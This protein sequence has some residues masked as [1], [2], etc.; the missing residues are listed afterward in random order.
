MPSSKS[1]CHI[2]FL[3]AVIDVCHSKIVNVLNVVYGLKHSGCT[4]YGFSASGTL[5]H[6]V[7]THVL[8]THA[9]TGHLAHT[10]DAHPRQRAPDAHVHVG[11]LAH[12]RC[13]CARR[14]PRAPSTNTE[15]HA[16]HLPARRTTRL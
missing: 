6:N 9:H 14:M 4:L 8:D 11:C 15:A 5:V 7:H 10:L 3:G 1:W 2:P 13:V 12:P 16:G